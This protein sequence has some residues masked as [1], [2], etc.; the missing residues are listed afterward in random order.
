MGEII[1]SWNVEDYEVLT[2]TGFEDIKAIHKT[3]PYDIVEFKTKTKTNK[4]SFN[5]LYFDE[6]KKQK[7][8]FDFNIGDLISTTNGTY[9]TEELI[10]IVELPKQ[11]NMFDLELGEGN[12][13][14]YTDSFLSHNTGMGKTSSMCGLTANFLRNGNDVLYITL[15]M[16]EEKIAQ[17]IDA[18]FLGV[19]INDVPFI[20]ESNYKKQ[21]Q[22]IKQ[23][24]KGRLVIKEFPPASI[25]VSNI[26][27]LMD[28]LK[29]KLGFQPV[30]VVVDYINLL[31]SDRVKSDN[32]YSVV[33]SITEELRGLMVEK[34]MCG[35]SAT[36]G[37]RATN[38]SNSSDIDLTNVSEC[39]DLY[40]RV[41]R[42]VF[43]EYKSCFIKDIKV[44]DIILGNEKDVT[45]KRVYPIKKK[46]MYTIT[47]KSGKEIIC[48][49]DHK[50][51]TNKG[52][53]NIKTG[54]KEGIEL[55][56]INY[57]TFIIDEIFSIEPLEIKECIDIEVSDDHLFYANDILTKNS[58]AL[59]STSDAIIGI[60]MPA[61]LR[62]KGM[63]LWK[64]LK[65][66]FGGILNIKI[67]MKVNFARAYVGDIDED[68]QIVI[69]GN[70]MANN[71]KMKTE[72]NRN[73]ERNK[74]SVSG[75]DSSGVEDDLFDMMED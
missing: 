31:N 48:S 14:Y 19:D 8:A 45:V 46:M 50:F 54:L 63:Q 68:N 27:F 7:Y 21:L 75:L 33:K 65:N 5:H 24:T 62:E 10:D 9:G 72:E 11:E 34:K 64:V 4:C 32:M 17:R 40:T 52:I 67:P 58:T 70:S 49:G 12:R 22:G 20:K 41:K 38:D 18:N 59:S 3:I 53:I 23:K 39:L 26:R 43:D 60:V 30:I 35:L 29:V 51:P 56:S 42:K 13:R 37:N 57:N 25:T 71:I 2:D 69:S 47:T 36:Q 74:I 15:E 73:I 61:D 66:R 55:K 16:A 28:E 1:E 44:G 6:N